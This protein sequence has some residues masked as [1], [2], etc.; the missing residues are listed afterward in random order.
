MI[1]L[2]GESLIYSM[3]STNNLFLTNYKHNSIKSPISKMTVIH[4]GMYIPNDIITQMEEQ[5]IA[6]YLPTTKN[7][8]CILFKFGEKDPVVVSKLIEKILN[9]T[10]ELMIYTEK[11]VYRFDY[12]NKS[13]KTITYAIVPIT[14]S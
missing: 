1:K 6:K 11:M 3:I 5:E 4:T 10:Y 9:D 14:I 7:E 8:Y 2:D 13:K 12:I